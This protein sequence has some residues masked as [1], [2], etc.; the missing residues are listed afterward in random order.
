VV[1]AAAD[2]LHRVLA[3]GGT[4]LSPSSCA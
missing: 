3:V 2:H 4:L 1:A